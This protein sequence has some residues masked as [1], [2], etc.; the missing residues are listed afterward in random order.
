ME[1]EIE[2]RDPSDEV[3]LDEDLLDEADSDA[4]EAYESAPIAVETEPA[5]FEDDDD[6][7]PVVIDTGVERPLAIAA[8]DDDDRF[9]L[10]DADDVAMDSGLPS[11][12][13]GYEQAAPDAETRF[14]GPRGFATAPPT[15]PADAPDPLDDEIGFGDLNSEEGTGTAQMSMEEVERLAAKETLRA[16]DIIATAHATDQM[17]AIEMSDLDEADG[18]G[19]TRARNLSGV[20]AGGESQNERA[21]PAARD[22]RKCAR[23]GGVAPRT[24]RGNRVAGAIINREHGVLE[25]SADAKHGQSR[26][27]TTDEHLLRAVAGNDE[28]HVEG[29]GPGAGLAET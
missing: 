1:R 12:R 7:I 14:G 6:L 17:S 21:V 2:I 19:A 28:A 22:E 8:P 16:P 26:S 27:D 20:N 9:S 11:H 24:V 13:G 25:D 29:A 5:A 15:L 10:D 18:G 4:L 23:R 3:E